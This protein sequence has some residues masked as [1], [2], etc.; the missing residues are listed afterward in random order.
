MAEEKKPGR[1]EKAGRFFKN[2]KG[3]MS[4]V[5]WP[6]R[7]QALNNTGIVL[8]FMTLSAVVVGAFDALMGLIVSIAFGG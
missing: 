6:S 8:V 2:I 3:E 7:K 1:F 5:V 4:R